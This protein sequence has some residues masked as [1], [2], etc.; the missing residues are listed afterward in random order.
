MGI[1][2]AGLAA[3]GFELCFQLFEIG[4]DGALHGEEDGSE[5]KVAKLEHENGG[6]E[7]AGSVLFGFDAEA[8][9]G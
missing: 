7:D 3:L 2:R 8:P 5:Y 1:R 6:T 4:A 9:F